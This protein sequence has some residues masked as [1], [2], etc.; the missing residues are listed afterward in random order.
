MTVSVHVYQPSTV[1]LFVQAHVFH[2]S[3]L[4]E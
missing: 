4:C 2:V 1:Q 3:Y